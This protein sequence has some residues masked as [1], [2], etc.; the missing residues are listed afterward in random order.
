M[1]AI[2]ITSI[3]DTMDFAGLYFIFAFCWFIPF[4]GKGAGV[5][6]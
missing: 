5:N 6:D 1:V 3:F 4:L 2:M